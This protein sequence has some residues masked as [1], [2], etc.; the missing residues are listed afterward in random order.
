[1]PWGILLYSEAR[2]VVAKNQRQQNPTRAYM[3]I[4]LLFLNAD[5]WLVGQCTLLNVMQGS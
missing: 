4:A 1:M 3:G 2:N 5:F